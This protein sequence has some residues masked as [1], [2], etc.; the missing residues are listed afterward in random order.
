MYNADKNSSN[1]KSIAG[2]TINLETNFNIKNIDKIDL[3]SGLI[4]IEA[5][6]TQ[7][8]KKKKYKNNKLNTAKRANLSKK[9]FEY[10]H[11]A[12]CRKLY[13]RAQYNDITYTQNNEN[14]KNIAIKAL[15]PHCYNKPSYQS[16]EPYLIK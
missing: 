7:L 1:T 4:V 12:K 5:N 13:T 9:N 11:I 8:S 14:S 2:S 10:I 15:P 3:I 16:Q 6:E